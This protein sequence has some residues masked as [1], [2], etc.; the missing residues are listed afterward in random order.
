[1][2]PLVGMCLVSVVGTA[3][4]C[5]ERLRLADVARVCA[6]AAST[7]DDPSATASAV[8]HDN[9]AVARTQL[10]PTG[11]FLTVTVRSASPLPGLGFIAARSAL[12]AS[13]SI[14]LERSPVLR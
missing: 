2:L 9:G 12:S 4:V 8:A 11:T 1:M 14:A 5:I 10:D 3:V 6:R 7:A 13:T